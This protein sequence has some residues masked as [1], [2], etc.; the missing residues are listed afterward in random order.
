MKEF[1]NNLIS[2]WWGIL[3][4]CLACAA[5]WVF[6]SALLYRVFFKR[7]YDMLLSL[8]AIIGLSPLLLLLTILGAIKMKGNP[9]FVQ[10]RPG[11]RK[12]LSGGQYGEEKIFKLLKFRTMT[13]AKDRNGNLLP[14]EKRLTKYGKFLRSTSLDELPELFNIFIGNM[15]IVGPRPLLVR[16]LP[17]YTDTERHRHDIRP[18]L[19]GLAQVNGRNYNSW[20]TTFGFDVEYLRRSSL[21]FDV[22]IILKTVYKVIKKG[23]VTTTTQGAGVDNKG[24][25]VYDALDIERVKKKE[26]KEIGSNFWQ[27][28]L[29]DNNKNLEIGVSNIYSTTFYKSGRNAI[30]ALCKVLSFADKKVL[31]PVFTC[32]TVIAPFLSENWNVDF[33]DISPNL[34]VN[35]NSLCEKIESFRPS[36]ILFHSYFG[37]DTLNN[38]KN[39]IDELKSKGIIIIEDITQSL[40]SEFEKTNADYFVASLRKFFAV[41][42]GGIIQTNREQILI[43]KKVHDSEIDDVAVRAFELKRKYIEECDENVDKEMFRCEYKKLNELISD[44]AEIEEISPLALTICRNIDKNNLCKRRIENYDYLDSHIKSEYIRVLGPLQSD[45][46][47][48]Y[49]PLYVNSADERDEL[50]KFMAERKIYCPVIWPIPNN[51]TVLTE[52]SKYIY[53]HILCVPIDQ[54]YDLNDMRIIVKAFD[55]YWLKGERQ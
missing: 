24:H 40:F 42:N 19:T 21:L 25:R 3:I 47:P 31:L 37:F 2:S 43:D 33:Y 13:N 52:N 16:Y 5:V 6:L 39:K 55:D 20:E 53:N 9:F 32:E 15:S 35:E 12:K 8:I 38:L 27:I 44:N 14:D 45:T 4:I 22:K 18:G 29:E 10:L 48:L 54:R 50:Q 11:K 49:F 28:D 51:L 17:Y 36:V 7:F 34:Q 26:R 41:P 30:K 1:F 23:D 46:V